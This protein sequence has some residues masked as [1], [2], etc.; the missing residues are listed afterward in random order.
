MCAGGDFKLAFDSF[1]WHCRACFLV[2]NLVLVLVP[3]SC[4]LF[5]DQF[6]LNPQ[7][8]PSP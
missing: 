3:C 5:L 4:S 1:R 2:Y 8:P 7:G 6:S